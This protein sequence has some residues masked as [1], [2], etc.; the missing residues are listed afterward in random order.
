MRDLFRLI[1]VAAMSFAV[2]G[3]AMVYSRGD[4]LVS[5]L[6]S[7]SAGLASSIAPATQSV[8]PVPPAENIIVVARPNAASWA[9]LAG[10][11]DQTEIVFPLRRE[12]NVTAGTL[13][14]VLESQLTQSGDGLLTVSV[15]GTARGQVVL[16]GGQARHE[17]RVV[18][19]PEDFEGDTLVLHLAGRGNTGGG[20]VCPTDGI[21]AG[22]AVTVL[23]ESRLELVSD[24]PI[25]PASTP[26]PR[27]SDA[28]AILPG[29]S[30]DDMAMAIWANQYLD[31]AGLSVHMGAARPG[32]TALVADP[33]GVVALR[34]EAPARPRATQWPVSFDQLE[35]DL[36]IKSFRGARQWLVDFSSADLPGGR[37]PEAARIA[38]TTAPLAAGGE[39]AVRVSLN[40][41][42][43]HSER[44]PG[45]T[46][47]I[48]LNVA[49]PAE[50]LAPPNRLGVEL[51]DTTPRQGSC[52]Q[53]E[54]VQAQL[55]PE[56]ALLDMTR[57]E[58]G[59]P[60]LIERLSGVASIALEA[61]AVLDPQQA[62][63][64]SALLGKLVPPDMVP[65]AGPAEVT[66]IV[67][68]REGLARR[69][70][71]NPDA[72]ITAVL[73]VR[74]RVG[75]GLTALPVPDA[76]LGAALEQLDRGDVILLVTGS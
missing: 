75:A 15:N 33:D 3:L 70:A 72:D 18:L 68:T 16:E 56:S 76:A 32:E 20:Q 12:V 36:A 51:V 10:F 54:Q 34:A 37:M 27:A 47:L 17:L 49:L 40:G 46:T 35:S 61:D 65:S 44:L 11:P 4:D 63:E 62:A 1:A 39:W 42:L 45:S 69:L 43:I 52:G 13:H 5:T 14:L 23:P 73:P 67:T 41:N 24:T 30:A 21:N 22:S 38:L 50:R 59:W 26:L 58:T 9:G 29:A 19:T 7:M 25:D 71:E 60:A 66:I 57:A 2:V 55:L 31:R 74:A 28:L 64:A 6:Q 48:D 8:A 53:A